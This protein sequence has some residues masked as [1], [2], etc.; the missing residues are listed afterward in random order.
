MHS[1]RCRVAVPALDLATILLALAHRR[2]DDR[3]AS[4]A[5][6]TPP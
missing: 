1:R 5:M 2:G 3:L 4:K 6:E